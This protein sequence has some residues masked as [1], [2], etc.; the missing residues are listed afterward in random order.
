MHNMIAKSP[1]NN[2]KIL[3]NYMYTKKRGNCNCVRAAT[4]SQNQRLREANSYSAIT[5]KRY[6]GRSD[7]TMML[8]MTVNTV[9]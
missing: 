2:K 5:L 8:M 9:R 7:L 4:V 1:K 6:E 3:N